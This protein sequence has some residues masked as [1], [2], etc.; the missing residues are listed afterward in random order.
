MS[1]RQRR[2]QPARRFLRESRWSIPAATEAL[3]EFVP[4][5]FEPITVGHLHNATI[6][7][8][9]PSPALRIALPKLLDRPLH[10]LFDGDLLEREWMG[11]RDNK[12]R[13]GTES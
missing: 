8:A 11:H 12:I 7:L 6:G 2:Y 5:D 10:D 9:A 4:D 1:A 3:N 13:A